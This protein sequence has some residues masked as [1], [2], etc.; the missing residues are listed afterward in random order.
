MDAM[1]ERLNP[2]RILV[3]GG[4][5][6]YDYKGIEVVYFGND[7]TERMETWEAEEQARE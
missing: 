7:T 6:D 1:I 3:Y 5:I 2:S 4:A